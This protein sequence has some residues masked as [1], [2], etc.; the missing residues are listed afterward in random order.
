MLVN[1]LELFE[2]TAEDP[3]NV[4]LRRA[5]LSRQSKM[6]VVQPGV[7]IVN[8]FNFDNDL[9]Y[10][11]AQALVETGKFKPIRAEDHRDV[12]IAA[13]EA[14]E[15]Y[16]SS[17]EYDRLR[18]ILKENPE[19]PVDFN[20]VKA[21]YGV[22]DT[23]EQV[24]AYYQKEIADPE[25]RYVIGLTEVRR[26]NQSPRGGWRWHK[27]GEYIGTREPTRE[28]LYDEPEIESVYCF[29]IIQIKVEIPWITN[30]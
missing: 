19:A 2:G 7:Y 12:W 6:K 5:G 4:E 22:A 13:K 24:I 3:I 26:E 14:V 17:A 25:K 8:N 20:S 16:P 10:R 1:I 29:H 9:N 23:P 21:D 11:I 28:Y 15:S 18:A 27:W 30:A